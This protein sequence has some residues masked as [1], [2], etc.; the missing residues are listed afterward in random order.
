MQAGVPLAQPGSPAASDLTAPPANRPST[1]Q[2]R[3]L[4]P[5][6]RLP[7]RAWIAQIQGVGGWEEV[8]DPTVTT[9]L[10]E[11]EHVQGEEEPPWGRLVDT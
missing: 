6:L 2:A 8:A 7:G 3:P 9:G 4:C 11:E 10:E 1:R 5:E